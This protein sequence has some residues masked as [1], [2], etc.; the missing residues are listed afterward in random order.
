[1]SALVL[2]LWALVRFRIL[3]KVTV[4]MTFFSTSFRSFF[5]VEPLLAN[6]KS[7]FFCLMNLRMDSG[8]G[9]FAVFLLFGLLF[10]RRFFRHKCFQLISCLFF[11]VFRLCSFLGGVGSIVVGVKTGNSQANMRG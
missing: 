11:A 9:F 2:G 1:M 4:Y 3:D 8:F 10:R 5:Q 7:R 6:R